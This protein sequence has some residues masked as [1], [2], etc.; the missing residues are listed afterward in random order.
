MRVFAL[1]AA[2]YA[3]AVPA[4]AYVTTST[5]WASLCYADSEVTASLVTKTQAAVTITETE[6]GT[7]YTVRPN[8]LTD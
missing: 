4:W 5:E 7:A 6:S 8:M 2:L 1:F 3:T